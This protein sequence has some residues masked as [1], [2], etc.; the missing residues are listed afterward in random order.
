VAFV[1]IKRK[2]I[3]NNV[4]RDILLSIREDKDVMKKKKN[5][6]LN[7]KPQKGLTTL[8]RKKRPKKDKV[9]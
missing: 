2:K 1:K 8:K 6:N 7:L 5:L 9:K 3:Y 4:Y